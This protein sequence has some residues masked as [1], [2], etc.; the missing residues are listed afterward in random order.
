[1]RFE[2]S[3]FGAR[4]SIGMPANNVTALLITV[5]IVACLVLVMSLAARF[6]H[7]ELQHEERMAALEKGQPLPPTAE[8]SAW[9][10]RAYLLRGLTWVF[11][12][13]GLM[14]FLLGMATTTHH[15]VSASDRVWRANNAKERGATEEQVREIMNDR[16]IGGIPPAIALIAL[17]PIGVGAAY[18]ITYRLERAS[19]P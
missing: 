2:T 10:P 16:E 17:I 5:L 19:L 8:A 6:K 15:E 11:T 4:V 7:R 14:V 18:L 12:G 13:V 9:S 3:T 1:M